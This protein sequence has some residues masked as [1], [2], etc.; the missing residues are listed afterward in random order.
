MVNAENPL[1][2][3]YK[4]DI[5]EETNLM[6][7][8]KEHETTGKYELSIRPWLEADWARK[9]LVNLL[10][11]FALY[12]CMHGKCIYATNSEEAWIVH[13]RKH[14]DLIDVMAKLKILTSHKRDEYIKFRDCPYCTKE[15]HAN[16]EVN[17]HM[18]LEHRRSGFQ[19]AHCF[20]RCIEMD[21]MVF[22]Y[23]N[24]HPDKSREVLLCSEKKEF[25]YKDKELIFEYLKEMKKIVCGQ[26]KKDTINS[27]ANIV[28]QHY[29]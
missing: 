15:S 28:N 22:H 7:V 29:F 26:G 25:E 27:I 2:N 12:K 20:Y 17:T 8:F 19:C 11:Q 18:E 1:A 21:Y 16:F 13:M 4:M 10:T 5:E 23:Q 9:P 6:G 3:M 14:I 24:F